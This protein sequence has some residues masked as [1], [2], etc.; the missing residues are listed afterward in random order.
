MFAD[1]A[2]RG[3]DAAREGELDPMARFFDIQARRF[4]GITRPVRRNENALTNNTT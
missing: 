2:L 3:N 1:V 4:N